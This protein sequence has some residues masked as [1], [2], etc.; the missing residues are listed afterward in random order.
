MRRIPGVFIACAL[1][2]LGPPASAKGCDSPDRTPRQQ[3]DAADVVFQGTVTAAR[4]LRS[5][6][7]TASFVVER[8]W[9]GQVAGVLVVQTPKGA[10]GVDLREGRTYTVFADRSGERFVTDAS[11]G[12]VPGSIAPGR[13]GLE[14]RPPAGSPPIPDVDFDIPE[15]VGWFWLVPVLFIVL[16][17]GGVVLNWWLKEKRRKEIAFFGVQQ[18]LSYSSYDPGVAMGGQPFELFFKGDGRGFENFLTGT[19]QGLDLAACDYWYYEEST[20]S[21]GRKSR[22]YYRFSVLV[23]PIDAACPQ[24]R[25]RPEGFFSRLADHVGFKD[26][27]FELDEFNRAFQVESEDRRFANAFVDQRMMRFL[28]Q[29]GRGWGFEVAGSRALVYHD[30]LMPAQLV[31]LL[32]TAKGFSDHVPRVIASLYARSGQG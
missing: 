3:V 10:C 22:T 5:K 26:I 13:Y 19:W 12:T 16:A 2:L 18:G 30:R 1:L 27:Q 21:E 20:D 29:A 7:R 11:M 15:S 28:L 6:V 4:P 8:A 24:L 31:Q 9:K 25:I 23:L 32:G 14:P 17:I